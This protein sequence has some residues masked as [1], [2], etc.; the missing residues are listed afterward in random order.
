MIALIAQ[1]LTAVTTESWSDALGPIVAIAS[2][3]FAGWSRLRA[4]RLRDM[5]HAV[6]IGVKATLDALPRDEGEALKTRIQIQAEA[7][8]VDDLLKVEVRAATT[9]PQPFMP[10]TDGLP[11][12]GGLLLLG[13][14]LGPLS[15]VSAA[16]HTSALSAQSSAQ[17][18]HAA[19]VPDPRYGPEEKAAWERLWTSHEA[20][21]K[22]IEEA[23]R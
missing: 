19:S 8:G 15:C 1:T 2:L 9:T 5:L 17:I 13:L 4:T 3:L 16:I 10:R 12:L 14:C 7:R 23:S 22:A 11:K 21:L 18:L 20:A 6:A